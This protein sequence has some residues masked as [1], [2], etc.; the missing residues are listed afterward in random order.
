MVLKLLKNSILGISEPENA[1]F[2]DIFVLMG[3][4]N[5]ML[6]PAEHGKSF[7]TSKPGSPGSCVG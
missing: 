3:I 6:S 5:F 2:L 7:L 1:E 4:Q